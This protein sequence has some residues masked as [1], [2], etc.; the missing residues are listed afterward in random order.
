MDKK[1]DRHQL[2]NNDLYELIPIFL[3]S[4]VID[5]SGKSFV[6][7]SDGI[8]KC[9]LTL[10]SYESGML[11]FVAKEYHKNSHIQTI[12]QT[13]LKLCNLYKTNLESV[14]IENI[15]GDVIYTS[16][17]FLDKNLN[18]YFTV[19]SLCDGVIL[20]ILSQIDLQIIANVWD[21]MEPFDD[22]WDYESFMIDED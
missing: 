3:E 14:V 20:S 18:N 2:D 21:N 15:V 10:N 17:K 7:L 19:V 22:D 1:I 13:F 6:I 4:V 11:T 8:K 5:T 16:L 12:H 9:A